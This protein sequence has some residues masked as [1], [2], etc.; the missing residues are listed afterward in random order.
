VELQC[1]SSL[2]RNR[3]LVGKTVEVLADGTSKKD[4][5]APSGRTRTNKTVVFGGPK[6][7]V[8]RFVRVK[9]TSATPYSLKGRMVT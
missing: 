2:A 1:R 9:V 6:N 7:V 8:G 5:S 3:A 4:P